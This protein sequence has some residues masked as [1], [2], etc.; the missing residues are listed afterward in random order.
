MEN[1][2][3]TK[4]III[5]VIPDDIHFLNRNDI[6]FQ[7]GLNS[8]ASHQTMDEIYSQSL[9]EMEKKLYLEKHISEANIYGDLEG[10]IHVD[11]RQRTPIMRVFCWDGESYLVDQYACK[12]PL[13]GRFNPRLLVVNGRIAERMNKKSDTLYSRV[14]KKAFDIAL[15]V[16]KHEFWKAQIEQIFVSDSDAFILVPKVGSQLIEFGDAEDIQTKFQNL[17]LFYQKVI[18]F[19]GWNKYKFINVQ[20]KNQIICRK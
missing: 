2:Q 5:S 4:T 18:N 15:Y 14:A 8:H 16:D 10:N 6:L 3:S 12:M 20:Y 7:L 1:K 13:S 19:S 17:E 11:V 9:S